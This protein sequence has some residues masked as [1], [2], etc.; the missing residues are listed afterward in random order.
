[1]DCAGFIPPW[2]EKELNWV[3][4]HYGRRIGVH[5]VECEGSEI[6]DTLRANS[7]VLVWTAVP[8]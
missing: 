2:K 8:T 7:L 1:M 5:R 3:D 6:R 4:T